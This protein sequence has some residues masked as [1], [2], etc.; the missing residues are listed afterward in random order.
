MPILPG[1]TSP[2]RLERVLRKGAFAV[3]TELDPP[4]SA[5][6][7]DV[8]RRA[9]IF[10]GYVDAINRGDW[11]QLDWFGQPVSSTQAA[12][13]QADGANADLVAVSYDDHDDKDKHD[14][15]HDKKD[16]KD[17]K[18]K[19]DKHDDDHDKKDKHDE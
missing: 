15:D 10:D 8:F 16:K 17:K 13:W 4:D 18:D 2:G 11:A 12:M 7:E 19:R 9:R 5:D 14:D 6:P 1:H 3:T